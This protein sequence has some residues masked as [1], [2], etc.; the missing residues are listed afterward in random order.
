MTRPSH[1][2]PWSATRRLFVVGLATAGLVLTGCSTG[3]NAINPGKPAQSQQQDGDGSSAPAPTPD[4]VAMV[5]APANG[6]KNVKVD[7]LVGVAASNGTLTKVTV[8]GP[9]KDR[10]GKVTTVAVSGAL[11]QAKTAWRA[12]NRLEPGVSYTVIS[13]GKNPE[14]TAA[15]T[16][17]TFTT[18]QLTLDDQTF[19]TVSPLPGTYGVAMPIVLTFDV[20]VTDR[21][22]FEQHLS[23]TASPKQEGSWSWYSASEVHYRPRT[24]WQPGT[25]IKMTAD[26]NS[27]AAGKGVYG[28]ESRTADYTIGR[29]VITKVDLDSRRAQVRIDGNVA[30][31]IKVSGGKSGFITRSGTKVINEKLAVTQMRSETVGINNNDPEA[32]DLKVK[33]AMRITNSGEF[34]HAAPWNVANMGIRNSSHGCIGMNTA[35]AQWLFNAVNI[36]DPVVVV[37][38]DRGLEKGN[39]WTDW[40]VSYAQFAKGSAL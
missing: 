36:G 33:W 18:Q 31:T 16:T 1:T 3:P 40:D 10:A 32:Y 19:A 27:V 5:A 17:S 22:A 23:V 37:G 25:K 6:T 29:S 38:T 21:K 34:L 8:S 7:T 39:G 26:L 20:P 4:P 14:G 30:R 24:Y 12:T 9:V 2:N 15:K 13:T 35:D 11:N 28:Q